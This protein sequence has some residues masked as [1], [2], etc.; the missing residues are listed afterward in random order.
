MFVWVGMAEDE[1]KNRIWIWK[2]SEQTFK[3]QKMKDVLNC[4][5]WEKSLNSKKEKKKKK[6]IYFF[7]PYCIFQIFFKFLQKS[8]HS[9]ITFK[10]IKMIIYP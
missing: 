8:S 4:C 2:F 9:R 7:E 6:K 1:Q 3:T 10:I 5:S